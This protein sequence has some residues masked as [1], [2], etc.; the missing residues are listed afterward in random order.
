M[1]C[2]FLFFV[3]LHA[4]SPKEVRI[5][6]SKGIAGY[7]ATTGEMLNIN[8][9]YSHHLFYKGIDEATGFK[10]RSGSMLLYIVYICVVPMQCCWVSHEKSSNKI[11]NGFNDNI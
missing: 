3:Q 5:P 7:V 4:Q 2:Q 11:I 10:T 1:A 6:S 9:A 8:D